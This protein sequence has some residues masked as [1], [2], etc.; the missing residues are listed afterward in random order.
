MHWALNDVK[1]GDPI[2]AA[3]LLGILGNWHEQEEVRAVY[4]EL[5]A[6]VQTHR[7]EIRFHR[8]DSFDI[9]VQVQNETA[10][11]LEPVS[12]EQSILKFAAKLGVGNVRGD[13]LRTIENEGA[14][15]L[16]TTYDDAEIEL[17]EASNGRAVIH[18]KKADTWDHPLG[19]V[20]I[21]DLELIKAVEHIEG[22]VGT[23]SVQ[24]GSPVIMGLGTNFP[25]SIGLGDIIHVQG[26]YVQVLR[27]D[28]ESVLVTDYIGWTS[29]NALTYNLYRAESRTVAAGPWRC[30][31]DVAL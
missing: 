21:W 15:V 29:E 22:S 11:S 13:P 26:R 27:R 4:P 6:T 31:G 2:V 8:G 14:T 3:K 28:T 18:I 24:E 7:Q 1:C 19:D 30:I 9:P 12:L 5:S 23:V 25:S 16:K 17:T 20:Y 10:C